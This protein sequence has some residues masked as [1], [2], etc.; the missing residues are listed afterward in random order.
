LKEINK[1]KRITTGQLKTMLSGFHPNT[2]ISFG[3]SKYR[4]RPLVFYRF[5][6]NDMDTLLIELNEID[7][8]SIPVS[9]C[10]CRITVSEILKGIE[11]YKD[12]TWVS[13]GATVDAVPLEFHSIEKAVAINLLQ[14][15]EPKW[16]VGEGTAIE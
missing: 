5:H 1:Q 2:P 6:F 4:K 8:C 9:E 13:F 7:E 11:P 12:D 16:I 15:Q 10:D 14:T 3:S